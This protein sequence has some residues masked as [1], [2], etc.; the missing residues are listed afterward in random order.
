MS[1]EPPTVDFWIARMR[2]WAVSITQEPDY[3]NARLT[4]LEALANSEQDTVPQL[5]RELCNAVREQK[6]AIIKIILAD[7]LR[8]EE[9]PPLPLIG[10]FISAVH[11]ALV[12]RGPQAAPALIQAYERSEVESQCR[13]PV[14]LVLADIGDASCDAFMSGI[15]IG[16]LE[17]SLRSEYDSD[18]RILATLDKGVAPARVDL[19]ARAQETLARIVDLYHAKRRLSSQK[20]TDL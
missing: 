12:S 4:D 7:T 3:W 13:I 6:D 17:P 5:I 1:T 18:E 19:N 15:E 20:E 14:L 11:A 10:D 9:R 8:P 2:K 16:D